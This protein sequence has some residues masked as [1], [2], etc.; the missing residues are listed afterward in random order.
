MNFELEIQPLPPIDAEQCVSP[1]PEVDAPMCRC[2]NDTGL[3]RQ[4]ACQKVIQGYSPAIHPPI[5][6]Q[7]SDCDARQHWPQGAVDRR[8]GAEACDQIHAHYY[9][10][11]L[12][13]P[14]PNRTAN[15]ARIENM[16]HGAVKTLP[17]TSLAV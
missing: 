13:E 11:A 6:C 14:K 7:A 1:I 16:M 10:L 17:P 12:R 5:L 9:L 4:D 2:C 3:I 15:Q 8:I